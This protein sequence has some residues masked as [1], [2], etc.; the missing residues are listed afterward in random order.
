MPAATK[1]TA[2]EGGSHAYKHSVDT[3]DLFKALSVAKAEFPDIPK[4]GFNPYFE[5][6][7]ATL[8][9]VKVATDAILAKNGLVISQFPSQTLTGEPALTTWLV[10]IESG[11]FIA[12]TAALSMGKKDP[13][14]QGS[15][16]TYLRR[17]TRKAILDLVDEE[18]DDDG[19]RATLKDADSAPKKVARLKAELEGYAKSKF[20]DRAAMQRFWGEN[21][22]SKYMDA[23]VEDLTQAVKLVKAL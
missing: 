4:T 14:A 13:Q 5:S 20:P 9:D 15:S 22:A 17:Y 19:N 12:D 23:S 18:N 16:L 6:N 1:A 7:F 10:H 11:Q 2:S 3:S 21:F 8:S